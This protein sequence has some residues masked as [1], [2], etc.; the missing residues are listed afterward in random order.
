MRQTRHMA[1][2]GVVA[3]GRIPLISHD[4]V[5]P[6]AEH[7]TSRDA[8]RHHGGRL[9][10]PVAAQWTDRGRK[11]NAALEGYSGEVGLIIVGRSPP[12]TFS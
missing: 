12:K 11:G 7:L 5:L 8:S 3:D 2:R 9:R 6:V 4:Q 1:G 10:E